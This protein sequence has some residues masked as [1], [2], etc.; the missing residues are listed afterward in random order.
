M[1]NKTFLV[2]LL[3]LEHFISEILMT[4][5]ADKFQEMQLSVIVNASGE[6]NNKPELHEINPCGVVILY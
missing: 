5:S 1:V 3:I 2:G 4:N 6:N